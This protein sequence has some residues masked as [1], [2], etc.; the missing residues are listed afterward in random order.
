MVKAKLTCRFADRLV[1]HFQSFGA[2]TG[3]CQ[4]ILR[5]YT[6][7]EPSCETKILVIRF[8]VV[9]EMKKSLYVG[10]FE[11]FAIFLL[12][13][14]IFQ[15]FETYTGLCQGI[16]RSYTPIEPSCET[17]ILVIC[18]FVGTEMKQSL[19]VGVLNNLQFFSQIWSF[20]V[21]WGLYRHMLRYF[22][23]LIPYRTFL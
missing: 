17:K 12:W 2:Y 10:N 15:S 14:V 3:L 18:F 6:P 21:I 9:T 23:V 16:L 8:V 11:R 5:S 20:L 22:E 7:T 1:G 4:G 13:V 19:Y